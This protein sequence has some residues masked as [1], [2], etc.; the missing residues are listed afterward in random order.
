MVEGIPEPVRPMA[1]PEPTIE[2]RVKALEL[3]NIELENRIGK[4]DRFILRVARDHSYQYG[5]TT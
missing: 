2:D 3:A 1:A 4:I 5:G